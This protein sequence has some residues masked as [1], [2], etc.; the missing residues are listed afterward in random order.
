MSDLPTYAYLNQI[1]DEYSAVLC[2]IWGVV[3]NGEIPFQDAVEALK[4]FRELYGPVILITNAPVPAEQ[5]L[6]TLARVGVEP[7]CYDAV[8]SSGDAAKYE[9]SRRAPGPVYQI[10]PEYDDPLYDGL[11]MEY[12]DKIEEAAC[13]SCW[14]GHDMC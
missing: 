3:H 8:V 11:A 10:G 4:R 9:L 13:V 5:V 2:D 1:A 6:N 14:S 7:D 12:T